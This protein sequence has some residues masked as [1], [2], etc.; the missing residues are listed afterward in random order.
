M[1]GREGARP[2][3]GN[4][5]ARHRP[6]FAMCASQTLDGSL[7]DSCELVDLRVTKALEGQGES[8]FLELVTDVSA[9]HGWEGRQMRFFCW[10]KGNKDSANCDKPK[11]CEPLAV[12][13]F[14]KS[15]FTR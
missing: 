11:F 3:G 14:C 10:G 2:T 5:F 1:H 6:G 8:Q 4:C 9:N 7:A 12:F 13:L 15:I